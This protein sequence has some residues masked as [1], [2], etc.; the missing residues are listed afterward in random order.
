MLNNR[1]AKHYII[2]RETHELTCASKMARRSKEQSNDDRFFSYD[3]EDLYV[4]AAGAFRRECPASR[5][6]DSL[7]AAARRQSRVRRMVSRRGD[8]SR[9]ESEKLSGPRR[10]RP[11]PRG[12]VPGSV[13]AVSFCLQSEFALSRVFSWFIQ[14]AILNYQV[15]FWPAKKRCWLVHSAML[16]ALIHSASSS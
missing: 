6:S 15:A 1:R 3:G 14:P 12:G 4:S 5:K 9:A 11:S 2:T 16:L 10:A 8:S 13:V 7:P